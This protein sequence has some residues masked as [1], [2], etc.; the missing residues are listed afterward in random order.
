[1]G[2]LIDKQR[3]EGI[4]PDNNHIVCKLNLFIKRTLTWKCLWQQRRSIQI[5][6]ID[7]IDYCVSIISKDTLSSP[8][9][10]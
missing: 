10:R 9:F 4:R 3:S 6:N 7:T 8:I 1:M 2:S 5:F